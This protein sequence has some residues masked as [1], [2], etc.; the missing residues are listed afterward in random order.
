MSDWIVVTW[1]PANISDWRPT[2]LSC[3]VIDEMASTTSVTAKSLSSKSSA[4]CLMQTC[5]SHP[6][7]KT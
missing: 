2:F 1:Q 4:V 5:V 3:M 6:Y 7:S